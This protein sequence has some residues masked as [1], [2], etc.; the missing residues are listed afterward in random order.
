M[1]EISD[2]VFKIIKFLNELKKW[3]TDKMRVWLK[4][5]SIKIKT[6]RYYGDEE[7]DNWT[8]KFTREV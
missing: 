5:E 4:M 7:C 2:K 8:G 3:C 1:Y 6:N